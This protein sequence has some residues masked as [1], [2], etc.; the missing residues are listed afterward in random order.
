[1]FS[2]QHKAWTGV[3]NFEIISVC[4]D[5]VEILYLAFTIYFWGYDSSFGTL[6]RRSIVRRYPDHPWPNLILLEISMSRL[7]L[8]VF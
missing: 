3:Y 8:E 4:T 2:L 6:D 5:Y 7:D 1:V